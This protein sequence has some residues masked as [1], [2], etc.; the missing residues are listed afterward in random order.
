[1]KK[2]FALVFLLIIGLLSQ[3]VWAKDEKDTPTNTNRGGTT[4]PTP[5]SQNP[6]PPN[7]PYMKEKESGLY[8]GGDSG[9]FIPLGG[10]SNVLS[11]QFLS[12]VKVG[13]SLKRRFNF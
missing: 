5:P 1:M 9:V 6:P 4:T 7:N 12:A 11:V 2:R 8:V 3:G 10:S 13:Y